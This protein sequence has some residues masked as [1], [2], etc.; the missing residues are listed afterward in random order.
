MG[1]LHV[2]QAAVRQAVS[3]M[4]RQGW[5]IPERRAKR[6]FYRV[7]AHG[8]RRIEGLSPRI[9]GPIVEWDGR[10]RMLTYRVSESG[11]KR[12]DRL[13]KDLT[14]LGWAPLS[15]STW[16]SP[17][18]ALDDARE[19][20]QANGAGGEIALFSALYQGPRSDRAL[21]DACWDLAGIAAA[22][23][24]FE[25]AYRPRLEAASSGLD[26]E[27][28]FVER[29]HLVHDFR[30]FTYIDPGLPSVL[31]PAA[32]SG[33]SAAALFRRYYAALKV[34]SDRFFERVAARQTI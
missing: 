2:S 15:A 23:D 5:L 14:V 31:L 20:A 9:Y 7:T 12:R 30:K 19:A 32:W 10:W 28:A 27:G 33:S 1:C 26:D 11:R 4:A 8:Q 13:R 29:M 22:Y 3:R 6:A 18:D 34:R 21:L 24:A 16:I 17:S 25:A